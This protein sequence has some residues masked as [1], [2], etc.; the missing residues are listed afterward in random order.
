MEH[1]DA[2]PTRIRPANAGQ[3]E[4]YV[5]TI[6]MVETPIA[7]IQPW[8]FECQV[9]AH[10]RISKSDSMHLLHDPHSSYDYQDENHQ[11]LVTTS[12]TAIDGQCPVPC[13]QAA[14]ENIC[15]RNTLLN[16]LP[17]SQTVSLV[18]PRKP[19][20]ISPQPKSKS[21]KTLSQLQRVANCFR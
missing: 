11:C 5:S 10:R 1:S 13:S 14:F 16:S 15:F 12:L 17:R 20:Q 18:L 8:Q 9:Q 21:S 2:G 4:L 19:E 6:G 7:L 3:F